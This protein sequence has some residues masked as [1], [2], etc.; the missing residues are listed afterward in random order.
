MDR[1]LKPPRENTRVRRGTGGAEV[2][3]LDESEGRT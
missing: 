1:M 2:M 3:K